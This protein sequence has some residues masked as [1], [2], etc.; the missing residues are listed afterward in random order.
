TGG[1]GSRLTS[2]PGFNKISFTGSTQTGRTVMAPAASAP[3]LS[4][5]TRPAPRPAAAPRTSSTDDFSDIE[6]ILKKHG[7]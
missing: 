2:H 1:L 3:S 7:I 5:A 6:A 4:P